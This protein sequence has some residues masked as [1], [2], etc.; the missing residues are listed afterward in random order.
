LATKTLYILNTAA[1]T[2]FFG[3]SLQ[4][5][6][7]APTAANTSFG[8][9]VAK[10]ATTSPFWRSR[11]GATAVAT[12]ASASSQ[13]DSTS[14]PTKGTGSAATTAGDSFV[15]GPF[16]GTFANTAWTFVMN[17]R[18]STAGAIGK[19][20]MRV[21]KSA[22][23]DG[24]SATALT[25]STLVTS[26]AKTLSTTADVDCGFTWSPG[27]VTLTNEY[28][29]FQVEW[30]E[31]TAGSANGSNAF[32][33]V[34]ST[35]TTPNFLNAYQ[36]PVVS[37]SLSL[38]M[39]AVAVPPL[40]SSTDKG[41]GITISGSGLTTTNTGSDGTNVGRGNQ[42]AA[43]ST[44]GYFEALA[45]SIDKV[46][47]AQATGIGLANLSAP[48]TSDL[49]VIDP[50]AA[51]YVDDGRV[52]AN[53]GGVVASGLA[54]FDD[55]DYV[56]IWLTG[57]SVK[58]YKAGTLVYTL[59]TAP[60]GTL[61]PAVDLG[62][63]GDSFTANFGKTAF[64]NIPTGAISWDGSRANVTWNP[65]DKG[66]TIVLS[67]GDLVATANATG[68]VGVRANISKTAGDAYFEIVVTGSN[69]P[70]IGLAN[71][72]QSLSTYIGDSSGT[73][74]LGLTNDGKIF[75]PGGNAGG[76]I[77]AADSSRAVVSGD[78]LGM[79]LVDANT[80]KVYKNGVL[81]YTWTSLPSGA[82][83]PAIAAGDAN[84]TATANFGASAMQYLPFGVKSWDGSRTGTSTIYTL[85]VAQTSLS[86]TQ[87][88]VLVP[89]SR[90]IS[91][92]QASLAL[93]QTAI[94]VAR[95]RLISVAQGSL[96]ISGQAI[97]LQAARKL[98][99]AQGS[100][101]ISSQAV[102][103]P[104]I[105]RLLPVAQS[106][107]SIAS[108][109]VDVFKGRTLVVASTALSLGQQTVGTIA[110]RKLPVDQGSLSISAQAVTLA[111]QRKLAIAATSLTLS[112]QSIDLAKAGASNHFDSTLKYN[113]CTLS[114]NDLTVTGN[115]G[116]GGGAICT[117]MSYATGKHYWEFHV[118]TAGGSGNLGFGVGDNTQ[119]FA[120][121]WEPGNDAHGGG[122][123][124][125][126]YAGYNGNWSQFLFYGSTNDVLM[127]AYDADNKRVWFGC[128]GTWGGPSF[129]T[130]D[131]AAGTGYLDMSSP[132]ITGDGFP[133]LWVGEG[134]VVTFRPLTSQQT[135]SA[136]TGFAGDAPSAVSYTLSVAQTSLALSQTAIAA[137]RSR[138]IDVAQTSLTLSQTA[139]A[140][141]R[142]RLID[143]AQTSLTISGQT[144]SIPCTRLFS[145][146]QSSLSISSQTINLFKGI[147]LA[148]A[149]SSLSLGQQPVGTVA[150]RKL[151]VDQ[152]ALSISQTAI[153][154]ART[155]L[156]SVAS[157][158]LAISAQTI[159][160]PRSR[161]IAVAQ[162]SLTISATAITIGKGTIYTLAVDPASLFV[163]GRAATAIT[164]NPS[165][166]YSAIL[167]S[168][169]NLTASL[170][171]D[172]GANVNVRSATAGVTNRYFEASY[173]SLIF[174]T[175]TAGI[176][177]SNSSQTLDNYVAAGTGN[178]IGYYG[179]GY[180]EHPSSGFS[181]VA[182][183]FGAGDI[184]GFWLLAT[185]AKVYK[186]GTLQFEGPLPSG[187]LYPTLSLRNNGD[188]GS[189]NFGATA[190][191]YQPDGSVAW[192]SPRANLI[193]V[194]LT[195]QR[196]LAIAQ[197]SLS[198]G[199]TAITLTKI[200]PT[201]YTLTV[202]QS[203]LALLQTAV[204]AARTR[205]ISVAQG[206]LTIS[207]KSVAVQAQRILPI[208]QATLSL[209][210]TAISLS[211]AAVFQI[212]VAKVSLGL[213]QQPVSLIAQRKLA[214]AQGT[215][216]I[217]TTNISAARTRLLSVAQG[218][219]TLSG[220]AVSLL[221]NRRIS[222]AQG[223]LTIA[224][225]AVQTLV[226]RKLNVT[227]T[228]LAITAQNITA[229]RNRVFVVNQAS[230]SL[231]MRLVA[232][233]KASQLGID[234]LPMSVA[235]AQQ[236]VSLLAQRKLSVAPH[237]SS[238]TP[239][240]LTVSR[241]R[242]ISVAQTSLTITARPVVTAAQRKLAVASVALTLT[243]VAI[244][245]Y[246]NRVFAVDRGTLTIS[247]KTV[248]TL[249][250]R[251]LGV[252]PISLTIAATDINAPQTRALSVA[253][254]ALALG[255]TA[256]GLRVDRKLTVAPTSLTIVGEALTAFNRRF[257]LIVASTQLGITRNPV[258]VQ[259]PVRFFPIA[260]SSLSIAP[261][262]VTIRAN[263]K[264]SVA[265]TSLS[266]TSGPLAILAQ[267]VFSIAKGT[268]T[269]NLRPTVGGRAVELV[270]DPL[271]INTAP[272]N[273]IFGRGYNFFIDRLTLVQSL[274]P[275][276]LA[277]HS[278][279]KP[280]IHIN[281]KISSQPVEASITFKSAPHPV[282]SF[283]SAP[284]EIGTVFKSGP[285]EIVQPNPRPQA[286]FE[287]HPEADVETAGG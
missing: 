9:T 281:A 277:R 193:P 109:T 140:V 215:L 7:S 194:G 144:V 242:L 113:G 190:F 210:P 280:S 53:G 223:S 267:R 157:S 209:S 117:T 186:N 18:A 63:I 182:A 269:I 70:E 73:N 80:A 125:N 107:L 195:V 112:H 72:S 98:P 145:V 44:N 255:M 231:T 189:I 135:Y 252:N 116:G 41:S 239:T 55:G 261:R 172:P 180:Y 165:D 115:S 152:S 206:S 246:A 282:S 71:A 212:D 45:V 153:N 228:S 197:A 192:D 40:W 143:V 4:E 196:K 160:I 270:I 78:V 124:P 118:D 219:L 151:A 101:S 154:A 184:I 76:Q 83:F 10:T 23:A 251:K 244:A 22:N 163:G 168:A 263:R 96:S 278:P 141:A 123:Y 204:N 245:A 114:N 271:V 6:G 62:N 176:A 181:G 230:L 16:S 225:T 24:T 178:G 14:G 253:K 173:S 136:P 257:T 111:Y 183:G 200:T 66:S 146:A 81:L 35:I 229:M 94:T 203:S 279:Y 213:T 188:V 105:T 15:A 235:L 39:K 87:T 149:S 201:V 248:M 8:W 32:F 237:G 61:Y 162:S 17:M 33:R 249:V 122:I 69:P 126:A 31:T 26:V 234:V 240:P 166:K 36:L 106:S 170:A 102:T 92:G 5:G 37:Q 155:R 75:G 1:A 218:S 283:K 119:S 227:Q 13:I 273:V 262:A 191:A 51:Q 224:G 54:T 250:N 85:A 259:V 131:P 88:A 89:R 233:L 287:L 185:T 95:T 46:K 91:V 120:T 147:N 221:S 129:S 104:K 139:I 64:Q 128:N 187:S 177:I 264:L 121:G 27:S 12:V 50:N 243:P 148:V 241:T 284:L 29:F 77:L 207:S 169:D 49:G 133:L 60:S 158:S 84:G 208:T 79:R 179:S 159:A 68:N 174:G 58:F 20:R 28:L 137:A 205:L 42:A 2:P 161:L 47:T 214:V 134:D 220:I 132:G 19:L 199:A 3:G 256:V 65:S 21:W 258:L 99:I 93:S 265:Q 268:L 285:V 43:I 275:V 130:G 90:L 48:L 254:M 232:V 164:L 67:G 38:S 286:V 198:I 82:L 202:D 247:T 100:L 266:V 171:I 142:T 52:A 276:V 110:A 59:T 150:T 86:L 30:N 167:L 56:G 175:G 211:K 260:V 216:S 57:T 108:Q 274:K 11:L 25:A 236:P 272:G 103:V 127:L 222:V 74:G 156:I 34:G 226:A 217:S 97:T 238:I 138:L